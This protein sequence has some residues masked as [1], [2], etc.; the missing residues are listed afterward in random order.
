MKKM[1][2]ATATTTLV[3]LGSLVM[4]P[5]AQADPYP[6]SIDTSCVAVADDTQVAPGEAV[7]VKFKWTAEGNVTPKGTVKWT[8][9][10][11]KTGTVETGSFWSG[12]AKKAVTKTFTFASKGNYYVEF[13][14]K[15]QKTS[16]FKNCSTSTSK[17][18]V[19]KRF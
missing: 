10:N 2:V 4:A 1:A 13:D 12:A 9:R 14:T 17:I 5:A 11:T 6:R 18:K 3:A 15:A 8:V 7:K 16:V 19:R